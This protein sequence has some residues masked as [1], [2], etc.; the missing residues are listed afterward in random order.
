MPAT[1]QILETKENLLN[2]LMLWRATQMEPR[3]VVMLE[4]AERAGTLSDIDTI[5]RIIYMPQLD[6]ADED[7]H[8]PYAQFLSQYQVQLRPQGQSMGKQ[9]PYDQA[10]DNTLPAL[11]RS[12]QLLDMRLFF[13]P[14]E[15]AH[16]RIFSASNMF[17]QSLIF[18]DS[19]RRAGAI[20]PP[21]EEWLEDVLGMIRSALL[22]APQPTPSAI[23]HQP[24]TTPANWWALDVQGGA[25][26]KSA[27]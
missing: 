21:L 24:R 6:L 7:G 13:L 19:R 14:M 4:A 27:D 16:M 15:V 11:R 26:V 2:K 20:L 5:L 12:I 8:H 25:P 22:T 10:D 23:A 18:Y 1:T 9:H 17:L 3:R